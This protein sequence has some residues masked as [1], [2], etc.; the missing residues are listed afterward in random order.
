M[1]EKSRACQPGDFYCEISLNESTW[2][3]AL[4]VT[5]LTQQLL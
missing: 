5:A 3:E 1:K 4:G 2:Y